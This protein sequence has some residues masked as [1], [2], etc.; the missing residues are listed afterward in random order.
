MKNIRALI[1]DDEI[2]ARSVLRTL[3]AKNCPN[4]SVEG[5][6]H[7]VMDAIQKINLYNPQLVFLDV[8]MPNYEGY[9]II[10][11][12]ETIDFE[13]IFT[14]AY[15]Q[16]ALKA[17]EVCA[18]DYL[19]KPIDRSKLIEAVSK[20]KSKL[21]LRN[22][23]DHYK[24]L[25]EKFYQKKNSDSKIIIPE[26]GNRR[27]IN[28]NDIVAIQA[29]GAYTIIHQTNGSKI[30]TSKNLKHFENKLESHFTFFRSH[31]SWIINVQHLHQ[32]NK[33]ESLLLMNN[34]V[35]AKISRTLYSKFEERL[36]PS[37]I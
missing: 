24:S 12:L 35:T 11:F 30:T 14:T 15:D 7:D 32:F 33:T 28:T 22:N 20:V 6:A 25:V 18:I 4:V 31:R 1:V 9:E 29:N 27:I 10:N 36:N 34:K 16:Y 17:F 23:L 3:L 37:L 26:L 5:E 19:L 2:R 21:N 8:E 13:I